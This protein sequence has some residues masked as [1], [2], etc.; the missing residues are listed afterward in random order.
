[1]DLWRL[2]GHCQRTPMPTFDVRLL[3]IWERHG[4]RGHAMPNQKFLTCQIHG[5]LEASFQARWLHQLRTVFL[6]NRAPSSG[7]SLDLFPNL[8]PHQ[9]LQKTKVSL[10]R[11]IDDRI[12]IAAF[13]IDQFVLNDEDA[14][15]SLYAL[16]NPTHSVGLVF[17]P[18][19][20]FLLGGSFS[21]QWRF[22]RIA[23]RDSLSIIFLI[24]S[25]DIWIGFRQ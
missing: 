16:A 21:G 6:A 3:A 24:T 1:M 9:C 20:E 4:K 8:V 10:L 17:P 19:Q 18:N 5:V 22:N 12:S 15:L 23:V 14:N 11:A 25:S 13:L 7:M 2:L